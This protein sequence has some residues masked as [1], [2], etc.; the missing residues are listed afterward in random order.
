M[1]VIEIINPQIDRRITRK[2]LKLLEL[3]PDHITGQ[4]V[5]SFYSSLGGGPY[6]FRYM[7]GFNKS[8]QVDVKLI[9]DNIFY[10]DFDMKGKLDQFRLKIENAIIEQAIEEL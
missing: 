7:I 6:E 3:Y 2:I 8:S 1:V 10:N 5:I 9:I 4:P